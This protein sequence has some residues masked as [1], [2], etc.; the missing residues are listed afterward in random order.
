METDM[1]GMQLY[2]GNFLPEC[3][4]TGG[5]QIQRRSAA[6]FETQL[7]P[8]GMNCY[9]FPS[10]VLRAGSH[11]HSETAYIFRLRG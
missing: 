8:N 7:Y 9:G 11:L 2:T 3:R 5:T 4:G 6:C 10:P 1:P